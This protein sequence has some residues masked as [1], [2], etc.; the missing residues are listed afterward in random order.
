M[1]SVSVYSESDSA[2]AAD[3][4]IV[5]TLCES[6]ADFQ[7]SVLLPFP[8]DRDLHTLKVLQ[9]RQYRALT[10]YVISF[11]THPHEYL[12]YIFTVSVMY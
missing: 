6:K 12:F 8:A 2:A 1:T 7:Q 5:F 11:E 9:H 10:Q 4:E 3:R